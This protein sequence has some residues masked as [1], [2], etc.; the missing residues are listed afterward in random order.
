MVTV[1]QRCISAKVKINNKV[2]A[3]IDQGA[4][5]LLGIVE[6]DQFE[7]ADYIAN[8]F[9]M[10]RIYNDHNNKMNLSIKEIKGSVLVISQFTLCASLDKGRR[11]SFLNAASP[12]VGEELYQY[13]IST[14][15][16]NN[17]QVKTGKFGADMDVELINQGPATF[18]L[19]SKS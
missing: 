8:K 7:D 12:S 5:I 3:E 9:A 15:I 6:G 19:D 11:P 17:I 1:I 14:L 13:F 2:I 16:E 4:V 18:I 10:L